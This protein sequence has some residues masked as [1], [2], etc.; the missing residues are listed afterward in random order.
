MSKRDNPGLH[1]LDCPVDIENAHVEHRHTVR[2]I[3]LDRSEDDCFAVTK[4]G[5]EGTVVHLPN[6][7]GNS[8]FARAV[9][10]I[11]SQ[12]QS[13]PID[14]ALQN[15]TSAVYDF[16]FDYNM[17]LVRRDAG[18]YSIRMDYSNVA[19]YWGA[20]VNSDGNKKRSVKE[21]V[22][23]FFSSKQDDWSG[24]F[25]NLDISNSSKLSDISKSDL[26]HLLFFDTQMCPTDQG[27]EGQ[28]IAVA[29]NGT[30]DVEFFYGFSLIATW[31]PSG[32]V[33]VHQS[34][35]FLHP[36]GTTSATFTV[37]GI[38]SLDTSQ[39]LNGK[40]ITKSSG[41]KSIGGHSLFKGW[42]SF[43]PYKEESFRLKTTGEQSQ[44]VSFNGHMEVKTQA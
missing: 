42:A 43:V 2:V 13:I 17:N 35:G 34:A 29:I 41:R 32:K 8:T 33:E 26:K 3:C 40:S 20:V 28:G 30:L 10:L 4:G 18:K 44:E 6:E 14:I 38:G 7:C 23:R 36:A 11:P 21:L 19:G 1:F 27:Q 37:A 22:D 16:T 24:K 15:P 31:D 39:K 12:D 9:S 25:S 5:V